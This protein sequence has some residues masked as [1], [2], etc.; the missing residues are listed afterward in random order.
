MNPP[1]GP[2]GPLDP[3]TAARLR[4]LLDPRPAPTGPVRRPEGPPAARL[5]GGDQLELA[6]NEPRPIVRGPERRV[7]RG[8]R[9][10]PWERVVLSEKRIERYPEVDREI[11]LGL[12]LASTSTASAQ[13]GF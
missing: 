13:L 8:G 10:E 2:G 3:E 12:L 6:L 5:E 1:R 4:Q 9:P 7:P 11:F